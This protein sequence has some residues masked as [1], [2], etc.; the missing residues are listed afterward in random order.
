MIERLLCFTAIEHHKVL[1]ESG[2]LL[3]VGVENKHFEP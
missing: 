1:Q 2:T 3:E